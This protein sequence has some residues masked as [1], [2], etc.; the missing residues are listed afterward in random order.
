MQGTNKTVSE[1]FEE[2]KE[3]MCDHYCKW[4]L[5]YMKEIEDPDL[6]EELLLKMKCEKCPLQKL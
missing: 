6:G 3:Q 4:P 1:M 2:I 5:E